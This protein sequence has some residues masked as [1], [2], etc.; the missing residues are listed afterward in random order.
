MDYNNDQNSLIK[1]AEVIIIDSD[2]DKEN[3]E[4]EKWR[5]SDSSINLEQSS[6]YRFNSIDMENDYDNYDDYNN[7]DSYDNY[8]SYDN[9][10]NDYDDYDNCNNFDDYNYDDYD[11]TMLETLLIVIVE[12]NL[13]GNCLLTNCE[14][15]G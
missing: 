1:S 10:D 13:I 6:L 2:C 8:N 7:Y 11:D 4:S 3:L 12:D 5:A 15:E 14:K 9:Y